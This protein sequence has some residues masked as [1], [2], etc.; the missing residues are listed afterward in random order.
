MTRRVRIKTRSGQALWIITPNINVES[1]INKKKSITFL[2]IFYA[3]AQKL[4]S[5]RR[6]S[7]QEEEMKKERVTVRMTLLELDNKVVQLKFFVNEM[8]KKEKELLSRKDIKKKIYDYK[9]YQ[10]F[11]ALTEGYLNTLHSIKEFLKE[12]DKALGKRFSRKIWEEEWFRLN[13]DLRNLF[14]H[15]ESPLVAIDQNKII[16]VF[17]R[18][19]ELL[20]SPRFFSDN[21]KDQRGRIK[22][23]IYCDNMEIDVIKFL[24]NWAKKYLDLIDKKETIEPIIG[25]YKNGRL[26]SKKVALGTLIEI[27]ENS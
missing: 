22:V 21:L 20:P 24:K 27:A 16:F 26:K 11:L 12:I 25:F 17:E 18:I 10:I 23:A 13:M 14:H 6:K 8:K 5:S 1:F 3:F 19:N 9:P 4:V 2:E 7:L 15:I